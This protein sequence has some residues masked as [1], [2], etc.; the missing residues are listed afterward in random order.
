VLLDVLQA[1]RKTEVEL[2]RHTDI[3]DRDFRLYS[4]EIITEWMLL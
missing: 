2:R 3:A 1:G 4:T